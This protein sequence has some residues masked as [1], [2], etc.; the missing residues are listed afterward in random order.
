MASSLI[1]AGEG[2][3]P[4]LGAA[5][6]FCQFAPNEIIVHAAANAIATMNAVW[7]PLTYARRI[8]GICVAENTVRRSVAPVPMTS[9]G[10]MEASADRRLEVNLASKALWPAETRNAPP[11]V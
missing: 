3:A 4:F 7:I 2:S 9:S 8:M 10:L 6:N 5:C 1:S 11:R